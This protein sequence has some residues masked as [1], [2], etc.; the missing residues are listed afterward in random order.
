M[1][2][3]DIN[4]NTK[5]IELSPPDKR[6]KVSIGFLRAFVAPIQYLMDKLLGAYRTGSNLFQWQ[7]NTFYNTGDKIISKQVV[8][9]AIN[10][11]YNDMPPSPNW[12]LYL[13]SFIGVD[14]R[15]LFNGQK[16]VLEYALNKRFFGNFRQPTTPLYP[17]VSDIYITNL[18]SF[19][20]GFRVGQTIG[21]TVAQHDIATYSAWV[22][23]A[24]AQGDLVVKGGLLYL[25]LQNS[26]NDEPPSAKW[27]VT[28][29]VGGRL[30]F[31]RVANF[32]INIPFSIYNQTNDSEI[33]G[34][35]DQLIPKGLFYTIT[36]Y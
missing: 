19:L 13:P 32:T 33:R 36:P 31:T 4:Y 16:L 21:S 20:S 7:P 11:N 15:V 27:H 14:E 34:F 29:T 35:V 6:S 1:G 17:H 28:D 9:E 3:F 10:L 30:P 18:D 5:T 25:S 24:Y 23:G 12:S 26:N 2:L 22:A 8:Y